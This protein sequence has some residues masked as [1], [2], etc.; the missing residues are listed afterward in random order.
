MKKISLPKRRSYLRYSIFLCFFYSYYPSFSQDKNQKSISIDLPDSITNL[1]EEAVS[2]RFKKILL[3]PVAQKDVFSNYI[4]FNSLE[5][6]LE[7]FD[8]KTITTSKIPEESM[9]FISKNQKYFTVTKLSENSKG[10]N[11]WFDVELKDNHNSVLCTGQIKGLNWDEG[12]DKV[13]PLEDGSGI[14]QIGHMM[15]ANLGVAYHLNEPSKTA[16][17]R[18][19]IEENDNSWNSRIVLNAKLNIIVI[20]YSIIKDSKSNEILN[21]IKCFD[22]KGNQLW[23]KSLLHESAQSDL[24]VSDEDGKIA[25]VCKKFKGREVTDIMHIWDKNGSALLEQEIGIDGR[26]NLIIQEYKGNQYFIVPSDNNKI[27]FVNL[28]E[29][30]V[31]NTPSNG[32]EKGCI[33]DGA[34]YFNC[35][36]HVYFEGEFIY[37]KEINTRQYVSKNN[38]LFLENFNH[39]K[40]GIDIPINGFLIK[41]ME[42]N[43][44]LYIVE[45]NYI[46]NNYPFNYYKISF[47]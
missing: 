33:K 5:N 26:Y 25:F 10:D 45:Q 8:G 27:Y 11:R 15:S 32:K 39:K 14:L 1:L 29:N 13:Y 3:T 9:V 38:R 17:K 36:I 24:Y 35:F 43:G 31:K 47:Q 23:S 20:A 41:V 37:K 40:S 30:V 7:V 44:N 46:I 2:Q 16:F 22:L 28:I 4:N 34:I 21:I 19:F 6:T 42:N 18:V 12:N